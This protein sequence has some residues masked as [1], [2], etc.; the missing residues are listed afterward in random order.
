MAAMKSKKARD[1]RYERRA[2][3]NFE[4]VIEE[5]EERRNVFNIEQRERRR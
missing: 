2:K 3:M 5:E 1:E 4:R